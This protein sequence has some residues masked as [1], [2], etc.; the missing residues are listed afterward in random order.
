MGIAQALNFG[1]SLSNSD[2]VAFLEDDDL[3]PENY[4]EIISSHLKN[5]DMIISKINKL[6]NNIVS[7]YKML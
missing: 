3:W 5:N 6:Q 2:Y 4:L 7:K 1:V